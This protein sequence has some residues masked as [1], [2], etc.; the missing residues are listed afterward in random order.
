MGPST[1]V[2][3]ITHQTQSVPSNKRGSVTEV[4]TRQCKGK[5]RVPVLKC[6]GFCK[7]SGSQVVCSS[8]TSSSE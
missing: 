4:W 7:V 5:R 1:P 3:R 2:G 6:L 8:K